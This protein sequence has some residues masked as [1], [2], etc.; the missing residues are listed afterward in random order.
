MMEN[1]IEAYQQLVILIVVE[2]DFQSFFD[3]IIILVVNLIEVFSS[4]EVPG[5]V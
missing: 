4:I 2:D 1:L 3:H 5:Q